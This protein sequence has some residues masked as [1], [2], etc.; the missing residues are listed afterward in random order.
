MGLLSAFPMDPTSQIAHGLGAKLPEF[1]AVPMALRTHTQL[2]SYCLIFIA[3]KF[4]GTPG[5]SYQVL[6]LQDGFSS[7][8]ANEAGA[9]FPA[10]NMA[11]YSGVTK[12]DCPWLSYMSSEHFSWALHC[13]FIRCGLLLSHQVLDSVSEEAR[14]VSIPFQRCPDPSPAHTGA[15][16]R[17][18]GHRHPDSRCCKPLERKCHSQGQA[19]R[20][21]CS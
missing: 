20:P 18:M 10:Q 17:A 11:D 14:T 21:Q 19:H 4:K 6:R 2:T 8:L 16:F 3:R 12:G 7:S 1:H 15:Q 13:S 5:I 9:A